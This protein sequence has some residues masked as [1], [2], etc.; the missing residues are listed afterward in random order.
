MENLNSTEDTINAISEQL[1]KVYKP[2]AGAQFR[3]AFFD[4]GITKQF[5][6]AHVIFCDRHV[7]SR[8][9]AEY[10]QT[11]QI[12]F[13][14]IEHWC[15]EQWEAVKVLSNLLSGGHEIEGH[16]IKGSFSRSYL[17]RQ[18]HHFRPESWPGWEFRSQRDRN[19]NWKEIYVPQG[20]LTARGKKSYRGP[21][22]AID[23]W[24]FGLPSSNPVGASVSMKD[25]ILT[26]LPD[27]RGRI[28]EAN[29]IDDELELKLEVDI[30]PE[31][32]L[33]ICL[34]FHSGLRVIVSI[35]HS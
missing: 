23:Y 13:I 34:N 9:Q 35:T 25:N 27:Y 7:L 6:T 4:D 3:L 18:S 26:F 12:K 2:Y 15:Q 8:Q 22:E 24:I 19:P 30:T 28:L 32:L 31:L 5:L 10:R 21:D 33:G 11:G 16:Q 14:F 20:R 17:H 1:R 29:W